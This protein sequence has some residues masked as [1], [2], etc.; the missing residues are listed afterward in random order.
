MFWSKE[1]RRRQLARMHKE[2][3]ELDENIRGDKNE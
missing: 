2:M 3:P 1:E